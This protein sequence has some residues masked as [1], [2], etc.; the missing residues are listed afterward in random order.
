MGD[1]KPTPEHACYVNEQIVDFDHDAERSERY[2]L[3][4]RFALYQ[5]V[6][7]SWCLALRVVDTR[8]NRQQEV[9]RIDTCHGEIHRH[10]FRAGSE[11]EIDRKLVLD[12]RVGMQQDVDR[13]YAE[14]YDYLVEHWDEFVERWR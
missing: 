8:T 13:I 7:R 3:F 2:H 10:L 14:E 5:G 11:A 4:A 1:Y 6:I 12:L 9:V